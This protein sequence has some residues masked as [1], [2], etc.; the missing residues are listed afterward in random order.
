Y[1]AAVRLNPLYGLAFRN[2]G[3]V[4]FYRAD[5]AA[6]AEDFRNAASGNRANAYSLLWYYV[7]GARANVDDRAGLEQGLA[8]LREEWPRPLV[9]HFLGRVSEADVMA[10]AA[11]DPAKR[12]ER[13]CEAYFFLGQRRI[14]A[15][16]A[17]DAIA[18]LRRALAIC[19]REIVEYD[20]TRMELTRLG[21][22]P[23]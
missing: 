17:A 16:A 13:E 18:V 3:R 5:F 23:R 9:L 1:S 7:A 6:A 14:L 4:H 21:A 20:A 2:R 19:P 11:A 12:A 8:A 15:G 10:A 22:P